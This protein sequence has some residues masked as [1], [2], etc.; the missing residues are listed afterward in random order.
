MRRNNLHL[1]A[2]DLALFW[3]VHGQAQNLVSNTGFASDLSGWLDFGSIAPGDGTRTW[4]ADD[5]DAIPTS[6]SAAFTV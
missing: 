4:N 5:I 3:C 1:L 6:G 2:G